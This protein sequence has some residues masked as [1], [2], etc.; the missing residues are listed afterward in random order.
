M[1]LSTHILDTTRG[2]PAAA[3]AVTLERR[4]PSGWAP[5]GGGTTNA[6]GR[7]ASLLAEGTTLEAGTYRV[8]FDVASYFA[9]LGV[10]AFYPEVFITFEVRAPS[11]HH[12]VPLLLSPFGYGTYRGS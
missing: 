11:E 7:V 5:A 1:G 2:K 8:G 12:H 3:V 9:G 10:E 6:D 4:G